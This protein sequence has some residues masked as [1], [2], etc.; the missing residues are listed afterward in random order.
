[1]KFAIMAGIVASIA[2]SISA[3]ADLI[4]NG[5]FEEG[6][7][8]PNINPNAQ[9][10]NPG[11]T[12]LTG[13]TVISNP[14]T[15]GNIDWLQNYWQN[16]DG[17]F[18]LDLNGGPLDGAIGAGGVQQTIS[19]VPGQTYNLTFQFAGNPEGIGG[20]RTMTVFA[21]ATTADYSFDTAGH[22]DTDM[23]W[24]LETLTFTATSDT[25]LVEFLSTTTDNLVM[26]P[27][28][29]DVSVNLA[30]PVLE[31]GTLTLLGGAIGA[32]SLLWNVSRV[33]AVK[34]LV[35]YHLRPAAGANNGW[36]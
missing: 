31:P 5:G 13:W 27:A 29:D 1:M 6:D 18:S 15:N 34:H 36:N 26:G 7:F 16:A 28:L 32:L 30:S 20:I 12:N 11:A 3:S 4:T 35:R 25:T 14:A 22:S 23:G 24:V 19:T 21:G 8:Q 17:N 33:K 10:L 2:V 9:I